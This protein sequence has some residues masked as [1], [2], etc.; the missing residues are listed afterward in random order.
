M[1]V[2]SARKSK[3]CQINIPPKTCIQQIGK[4][5]FLYKRHRLNSLPN[6][7]I[8]DPINIQTSIYAQPYKHVQ[9][10]QPWAKKC[11]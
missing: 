3:K 9:N 8:R 6:T 7:Y 1:R 10:L 5:V 4:D 11:L 2:R